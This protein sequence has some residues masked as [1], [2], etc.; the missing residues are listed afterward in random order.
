[1]DVRPP[2]IGVSQKPK[3]LEKSFHAFLHGYNP[4]DPNIPKSSLILHNKWG[5][6]KKRFDQSQS[7]DFDLGLD[8]YK[9]KGGHRTLTVSLLK[10]IKDY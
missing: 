9:R 1:M 8:T 5:I 4:N 6:P 3:D 10:F 2:W 7:D